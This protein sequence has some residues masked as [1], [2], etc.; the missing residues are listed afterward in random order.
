MC[1]RDDRPYKQSLREALTPAQAET[2]RKSPQTL[3]RDLASKI[4]L[5][6][7]YNPGMFRQS[8]TSTY[9]SGV[10]DALNRSIAFVAIC[11]SLGIPARIDPVSHTTQYAD[12]VGNW[13]DVTFPSTASEPTAQAEDKSV[14]HLNNISSLNGRDPKYYAQFT[15]SQIN[16]GQPSLMDFYFIPVF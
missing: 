6:R 10:A 8:A 9:N 2:Y 12:T 5:D 7:L 3:V 13:Q 16:D 11:R 15:V 1:G 4:S 14:L